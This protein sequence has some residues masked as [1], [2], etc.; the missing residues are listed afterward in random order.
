LTLLNDRTKEFKPPTKRFM[1]MVCSSLI[2]N[3]SWLHIFYQKPDGLFKSAV[4]PFIFNFNQSAQTGLFGVSDLELHPLGRSGNFQ[5]VG[6][7]NSDLG[8]LVGISRS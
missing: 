1:R 5:Y 6:I 2:S 8:Q 7:H 4:F 3:F